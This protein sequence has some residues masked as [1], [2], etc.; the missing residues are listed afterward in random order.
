[1]KFVL[2]WFVQNL[3]CICILFIFSISVYGQN[4]PSIVIDGKVVETTYIP[5]S[6]VDTAVDWAV[7][8]ANDDVHWGYHWTDGWGGQ[9]YHC[10][11][12]VISAYKAAGYDMGACQCVKFP[13]RSM[14]YGFT[15]VTSIVDLNTGAGLEKGDVLWMEHPGGKH[16]HVE[17]YI[18][19][20]MLAGARGLGI[21][22]DI[23]GDQDGSEISVI[24]YTNLN[25][26][27]AFRPPDNLKSSIVIEDVVSVTEPIVIEEIEDPIIIES[28][29][30]NLEDVSEEDINEKKL[31]ARMY[32]AL[33][34]ASSVFLSSLFV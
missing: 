5:D 16:G 34:M 23:L 26:Q 18:G 3:L 27:R 19:D 13:E 14:R 25:F 10:I 11:G 17:L 21:N 24:P 15:D 9:G 12:F 28:V 1:M 6:V 29:E 30:D 33:G 31:D 22:N 8:V 32:V 4:V 7:A 2:K 20:G